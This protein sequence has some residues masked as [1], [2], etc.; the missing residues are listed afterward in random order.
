M[1]KTLTTTC[2]MIVIT[3]AFC[4]VQ[5][6]YLFFCNVNYIW[7]Y[8]YITLIFCVKVRDIEFVKILIAFGADVNRKN[9]K[10]MTPL[11]FCTGTQRFLHRH[12]SFLEV[13]FAQP[14]RGSAQQEEKETNEL[15]TLLKE[16]GG[17]SGKRHTIIYDSHTT[18]KNIATYLK[19]HTPEEEQQLLSNTYKSHYGT[20]WCTKLA[21]IYY[22]SWI[23]VMSDPKLSFLFSFHSSH[24]VATAIGSKSRKMRL[25]QMAGSRILVMDGGGM[26]ALVEIETLDQIEKLSGKKIIEL[27]DWIVGT[28]AGAIIALALVHGKHVYKTK[29]KFI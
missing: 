5:I 24:E 10:S 22:N 11:D 28:S 13:G 19:W 14:K 16:C 27:F 9:N 7:S 1:L 25:V 2:I 17:Q 4:P 3:T 12:D 29:K 15:A 20:D 8:Y 21:M 18:V 6:Y 23:A 26:K